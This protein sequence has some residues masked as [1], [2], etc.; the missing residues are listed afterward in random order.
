MEKLNRGKPAHV[1]EYMGELDRILGNICLHQ[2]QANA[3][4]QIGSNMTR[5]MV[6]L[7]VV[8]LLFV[9]VLCYINVFHGYP[10]K[11]VIYM[12]VVWTVSNL[13]LRMWERYAHS[14]RAPGA[15]CFKFDYEV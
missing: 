2:E 8:N 3:H 9:G 14:K 13:V 1:L 7:T 11:P 5:E 4:H 6:L 15:F 12:N 10:T